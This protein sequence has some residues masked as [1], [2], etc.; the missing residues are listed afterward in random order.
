MQEQQ[1]QLQSAGNGGGVGGVATTHMPLSSEVPGPAAKALSKDS[2]K[3][4]S[5]DLFPH[6]PGIK[7]PDAPRLG[8]I[9]SGTKER[10][11]SLFGAATK[12]DPTRNDR[13]DRAGLRRG[14][15]D[16][17]RRAPRPLWTAP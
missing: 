14:R 8:R 10:A 5:R 16:P 2:S 11:K 3:R 13:L 12:V 4:R 1:Q 15:G 9:A 17:H 7:L 6:L